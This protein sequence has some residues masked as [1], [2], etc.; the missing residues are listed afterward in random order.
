MANQ[1]RRR[2]VADAGVPPMKRADGPMGCSECA[3][4]KRVG[5]SMNR[6]AYFCAE[7]NIR[8]RRIGRE[9]VQ[10]E[11]T[12][13]DLVRS[14]IRRLVCFSWQYL[15]LHFGAIR[16]SSSFAKVLSK[17]YASLEHYFSQAG[18]SRVGTPAWRANK[19]MVS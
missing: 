16:P 12:R 14:A 19:A 11:N 13:L 8:H 18:I 3:N 7:M 17:S 2:R 10:I 4:A 6:L 15:P 9:N 1:A 5:I